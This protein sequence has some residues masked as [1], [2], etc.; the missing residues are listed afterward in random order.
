MSEMCPLLG[1]WTLDELTSR[2]GSIDRSAALKALVTWV[3]MGVLKEDGENTFRLL[4]LTENRTPGAQG[5]A[6]RPVGCDRISS[7]FEPH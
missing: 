3:D 2:V 6:P 7:K 5:I 4:E 1:V